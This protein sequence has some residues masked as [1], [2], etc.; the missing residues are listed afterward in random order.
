MSSKSIKRIM[1]D[2]KKYEQSNIIDNGVFCI[3]DDDNIQ[4]VK[5]LIIGPEDT[6][7]TN[8]FYFFDIEFTNRYPFS[9][10]KVKFH[11]LNKAVRFNPNYYN[12]GKV[13][14]SILGTW[15]GPGWSP[16]M[17]L[18]TVLN[19]LQSRLNEHPIQN[20]PGY[21]NE[22]GEKSITYNKLLAYY[23]IKVA[24]IQMLN[25]IPPGFEQFK[26]IIVTK[27]IKYR[28]FY[29]NFLLENTIDDGKQ[30]TAKVY[31][32]GTTLYYTRLIDELIEL[33]NKLIS[34]YPQYYTDNNVNIGITLPDSI[35]TYVND[36][37]TL[38]NSK[39]MKNS[40]G[41][42]TQSEISTLPTLEPISSVELTTTT[43]GTSS[44]NDQP[45][46][47][48]PKINIE[49]KKKHSRKCPNEPA[50]NYETGTTKISENDG[51]TY[52]VNQYSSGMKRWVKT[53]S[54]TSVT[55]TQSN[56]QITMV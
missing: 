7:Y 41:K 50:K 30:V 18:V 26:D 19:V 8:G 31:N 12:C 1:C 17:N 36:D 20:E 40:N 28:E 15:S 29:N 14:L 23:N 6:P 56:T 49:Q 47:N 2:I 4:K 42:N 33:D 21:E 34:E 39:N 25:N 9:P 44:T 48:T 35:N 22:T 53:N 10:P 37:C 55:P 38:K 46:N 51:N 13:C 43:F 52:I 11:T 54:I 16:A 3:F 32:M 27:Y 5:A 24:V 45:N